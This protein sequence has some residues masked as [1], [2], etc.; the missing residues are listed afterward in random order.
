MAPRYTFAVGDCFRVLYTSRG[1]VGYYSGQIAV[2]DQAVKCLRLRQEMGTPEKPSTKHTE[3]PDTKGSERLQALLTSQ[4]QLNIGEPSLLAIATDFRCPWIY[5]KYQSDN[6]LPISHLAIPP[7]TLTDYCGPPLRPSG[8]RSE[9]IILVNCSGKVPNLREF[10]HPF[11]F[12]HCGELRQKQ[13]P[14]PLVR[15]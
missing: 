15:C 6:T 12:S 5:Y 4:L 13:P 2:R 9:W 7:L 10:F 8:A 11:F 1:R 14:F 3:K